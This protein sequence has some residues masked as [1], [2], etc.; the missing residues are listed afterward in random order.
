MCTH[1]PRTF[2]VSAS[3]SPSSC[4]ALRA[5]LEG[6]GYF[7]DLDLKMNKEQEYLMHVEQFFYFI[8]WLH[9]AQAPLPLCSL[10]RALV[11]HIYN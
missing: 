1:T 3:W 2:S 6:Y 8:L 7:W 4:L 10:L 9:C 11:L 5:K